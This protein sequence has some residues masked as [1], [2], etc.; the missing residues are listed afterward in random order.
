MKKLSKK[1][2]N[3]LILLYI[4]AIISFFII[5]IASKIPEIQS[6]LSEIKLLEDNI[7]SVESLKYDEKELI[8]YFKN[9]TIAVNEEKNRYFKKEERDFNSLSLE[10]L[11]LAQKYNLKYSRLSKV[12]NKSN[13]YIELVL[14]GSP[15]NVLAF[16]KEIYE[17]PKY[18]NIY[19]LSLNYLNNNIL[20]VSLKLNYGE[21]LS[22]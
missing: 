17:R 13:G 11:K 15:L 14:N 8:D 5:F 16:F 7:N 9:L 6:A 19:Y 20:S 10:I 12:D 1:E 3:L 2:K 21:V 4:I 22:N 18:I